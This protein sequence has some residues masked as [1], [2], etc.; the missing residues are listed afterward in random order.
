MNAFI[1]QRKDIYPR[2]HV[3]VV[4]ISM[5]LAAPNSG[6]S[7]PSMDYPQELRRQLRSSR[8]REVSTMTTREKFAVGKLIIW[9]RS[10]RDLSCK[11]LLDI[12]QPDLNPR[13]KRIFAVANSVMSFKNI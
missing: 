12:H 3:I 4:F 5:P 11:S 9:V 1:V 6:V 10:A 7:S 13:I 8:A 2:P